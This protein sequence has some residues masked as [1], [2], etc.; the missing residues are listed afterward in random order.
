MTSQAKTRTE[1]DSIGPI[2][3]PA[4]CYWG[5]QTGRSLIHFSIGHDLIPIEVIRA[6]GVLK[7]AAAPNRLHG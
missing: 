2:D 7:K 3:V 5:A 4:D 1:R 6:F